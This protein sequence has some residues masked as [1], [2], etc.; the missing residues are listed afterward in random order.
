V[1][2]PSHS[3]HEATLAA[4]RFFEDEDHPIALTLAQDACTSDGPE[5]A[6][7]AAKYLEGR[8]LW[9]LEDD[10]RSAAQLRE[11]V[12]C[13]ASDDRYTVTSKVDWMECGEHF[14]ARWGGARY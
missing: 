12:G 8:A 1:S 5:N 3:K 9:L 6:F 10:G 14:W 11:A 13:T 7:D 2:D 4:I